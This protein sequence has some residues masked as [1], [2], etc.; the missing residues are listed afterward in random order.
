MGVAAAA[1]S[2][3]QFLMVPVEGFL[4]RGFGWQE[5]LLALSLVVLLI[6]PLA[7]GLREPGFAGGARTTARPDDR[8]RRCA[9]P[10]STRASSC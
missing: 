3:G 5:A 4:I 9:R 1:G 2:F 7:F 8:C 6:V 10:S